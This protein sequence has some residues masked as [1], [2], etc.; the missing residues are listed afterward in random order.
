MNFDSLS[1][2]FLNSMNFSL[3]Y[4]NFNENTNNKQTVIS[5]LI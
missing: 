5:L 1:F 2:Y 3:C 4:I